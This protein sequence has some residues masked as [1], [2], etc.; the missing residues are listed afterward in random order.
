MT[1]NVR[2]TWCVP[3]DTFGTSEKLVFV[4]AKKYKGILRRRQAK[5]IKHAHRRKLTWILPKS[6]NNKTTFIVKMNS[7]EEEQGSQ[8]VDKIKGKGVI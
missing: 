7:L 3:S 4:N 5:Q 1:K 8:G 6:I 2:G